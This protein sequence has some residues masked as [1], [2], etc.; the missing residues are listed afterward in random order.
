M[1]ASRAT[2]NAALPMEPFTKRTVRKA[3]TDVEISFFDEKNSQKHMEAN[4]MP[5]VYVDRNWYN[6]VLVKTFCDGPTF[7]QF[8]VNGKCSLGISVAI[9]L[10]LLYFNPRTRDFPSST[11]PVEIGPPGQHDLIN[12]GYDLIQDALDH[13]EFPVWRL[14]PKCR[15]GESSFVDREHRPL[16]FTV[17]RTV[18]QADD[19]VEVLFYDRK[20]VLCTCHMRVY[21]NRDWY[22]RTVIPY[23]STAPTYEDFA[24]EPLKKCAIF[25]Y[26]GMLLGLL[27]WDNNPDHYPNP[28]GPNGP[29]VHA[30][31]HDDDDG[32]EA[33]TE[34]EDDKEDGDD[35]ED[36]WEDVDDDEEAEVEGERDG[37]ENNKEIDPNIKHD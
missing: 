21:V 28:N 8:S 20:K 1:R 11:G 6:T 27:F 34:D 33:E 36:Q 37:Q 25:I 12:A 10:G 24:P 15:G 32:T 4:D 16:E 19:D 35:D 14:E 29:P 2:S 18:K 9:S 17:S 31:E 3:D 26:T 30:N 13:E 23:T 5:F 7:E 22:N